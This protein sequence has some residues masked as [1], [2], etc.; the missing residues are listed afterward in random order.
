MFGNNKR[1]PVKYNCHRTA[2][3]GHPTIRGTYPL[4]SRMSVD[5]CTMTIVLDPIPFRYLST[6]VLFRFG[7]LPTGILPTCFIVP[8][9][10]MDMLS[11]P[12]LAT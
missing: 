11:E 8:A 7:T 5:C 1:D 6:A 4:N 3:N 2:I 12:A 10:T 9:S